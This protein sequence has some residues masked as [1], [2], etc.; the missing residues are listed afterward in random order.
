MKAIVAM[1]QDRVI[2]AQGK[3]PWHLPEDFRWFRAAT[4]THAVLMG[5]KTLESIGRPLP[6]RLNLVATRGTA[7]DIPGVVTITDLS[8][9]D[10]K[11]FAPREVWVAGGAEIYA[12]MLPQCAE[13]YVSLVE[14]QYAGDTFFPPFEDDYDFVAVVRPGAGFEVRKYR[15]KD[16]QTR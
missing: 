2:G 9:F 14:G 12:Q 6:G 16:G 5:R 10:E 1:T 11:D 13:L 7:I 4:L 3:M 8:A 15:R